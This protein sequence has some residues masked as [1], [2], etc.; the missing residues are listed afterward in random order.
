M[1]AHTRS[2]KNTKR[3][4]TLLSTR[5][6]SKTDQ[7]NASKHSSVAATP[8]PASATSERNHD[9]RGGDTQS[10][11][12]PTPVKNTMVKSGSGMGIGGTGTN[13]AGVATSSLPPPPD[14][15]THIVN[16]RSDLCVS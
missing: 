7:S 14:P 3:T 12:P 10:G 1:Y 8:V 6:G 9:S 13:K 16:H 2:G 5:F 11:N 15:Y 4:L